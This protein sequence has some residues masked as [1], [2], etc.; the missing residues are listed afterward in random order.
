MDK[1]DGWMEGGRE[2]ESIATPEINKMETMK[3]LK[4]NVKI[5]R[6][7]WKRIIRNC[8]ITM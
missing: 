3:M 5:P 6:I 1:Q 2:N 7:D 4:P 8:L